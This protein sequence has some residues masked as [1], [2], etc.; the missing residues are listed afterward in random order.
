MWLF[1]AKFGDSKARNAQS[2]SKSYREKI[3]CHKIVIFLTLYSFLVLNIL[4][5]SEA[6]KIEAS[7][8]KSKGN[9][10]NLRDAI[11]KLN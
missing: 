1:E 10:Q 11:A 5:T 3:S 6:V 7:G 2:K 9:L 8:F 4:R